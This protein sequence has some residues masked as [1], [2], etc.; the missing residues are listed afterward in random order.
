M[1]TELSRNI[2]GSLLPSSDPRILTP[3]KYADGVLVVIPL[4][5]EDTHALVFR[6][7]DAETT[8]ASHPNGYSCHSLA[9]RIISGNHQSVSEQAAYIVACGGTSL[10]TD[11]IF[12]T[13]HNATER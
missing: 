12:K 10:S 11:E 3:I 4:P 6:R 9:E 2:G 13:I 7:G 8:L 5:T 1:K